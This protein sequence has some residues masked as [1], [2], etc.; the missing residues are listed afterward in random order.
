MCLR[1]D[2]GPDLSKSEDYRT[3][4]VVTV[5]CDPPAA[6]LRT[7]WQ[8]FQPT[9]IRWP[10]RRAATS[11]MCLVWH[12]GCAGQRQEARSDLR[13]RMVDSTGW[14]IQQISVGRCR[15]R[16]RM[17]YAVLRSSESTLSFLNPVVINMDTPVHS[18][19]I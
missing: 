4:Q 7:S 17:P 16:A 5:G 6:T 11:Q 13:P 3:R 8:P 10:C 2:C 15:I 1:G 19:H 18:R 14:S 9:R 12:S